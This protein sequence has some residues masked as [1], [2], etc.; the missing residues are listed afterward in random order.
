MLKEPAD[1]GM[2]DDGEAGFREDG[3]MAAAEI[4]RAGHH[5]NRFR[6]AH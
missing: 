2:L 4:G 6:R 3:A 5:M 1:I